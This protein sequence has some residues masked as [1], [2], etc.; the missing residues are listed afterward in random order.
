MNTTGG[1]RQGRPH[2]GPHAGG[3]GVHLFHFLCLKDALNAQWLFTG[4]R[5]DKHVM[6]YSWTSVTRFDEILKVFGN[7][8][9]FSLV[10]GKILNLLWLFLEAK[11]STWQNFEPSLAIWWMDK[12]WTNNQAI[13]SHCPKRTHLSL[14]LTTHTPLC[15]SQSH[16]L[17]FQTAP[18]LIRRVQEC[19]WH[20]LYLV[21]KI[22][23]QLHHQVQLVPTYIVRVE[24]FVLLGG[25]GFLNR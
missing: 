9:R 14:S 10:F 24:K 7:F 17:S 16:K 1:R 8:C 18:I 19:Y 5:L 2:R 4:L 13:W 11:L 22:P 15:L 21:V 6:G 12:Y 20:N 23:Q 3:D 25:E